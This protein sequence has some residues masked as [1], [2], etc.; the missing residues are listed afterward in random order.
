M[1]MR[2]L[3]PYLVTGPLL[4]AVNLAEIKLHLR[5][6]DDDRDLIIQD[7]IDAAIADYDGFSGG[8]N[9]CLV[10]QTWAEKMDYL[11]AIRIQL[12]LY[13][14]SSITSVTYYDTNNAVQTLSPSVYRLQNQNAAAYLELVDGQDWPTVYDRDDAVTI[15]YVCGYGASPSDVPANIRAAIKLHVEAHYESPDQKDV[16][17]LEMAQERLTAKFRRVGF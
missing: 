7:L 2:R 17:R 5:V 15:T 16:D 6:E 11:S 13:P 8:L 3:D 9:R 10:N 12:T 4:P 14:V 1:T